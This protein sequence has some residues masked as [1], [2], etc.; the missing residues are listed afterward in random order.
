MAQKTPQDTLLNGIVQI[1][2]CLK[3]TNPKDYNPV[4]ASVYSPEHNPVVTLLGKQGR[5]ASIEVYDSPGGYTYPCQFINVKIKS[6]DFAYEELYQ[7]LIDLFRHAYD[8]NMVPAALGPS[9]HSVRMP[10]I[11]NLQDASE[12]ERECRNWMGNVE[13][14]NSQLGEL[15]YGCPEALYKGLRA[16]F[17]EKGNQSGIPAVTFA[18]IMEENKRD[19][20]GISGLIGS[21]LKEGSLHLIIVDAFDS[22]GNFTPKETQGAYEDLRQLAQGNHIKF[23]ILSSP[24]DQYLLAHPKSGHPFYNWCEITRLDYNP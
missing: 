20:K 1:I 13:F 18:A 22:S 2:D 16:A 14:H 8:V 6:P 7:R 15:Y 21:S 19:A 3:E 24:K 9:I 17:L 23:H 10:K 5:I 11:G 4:K 12:L